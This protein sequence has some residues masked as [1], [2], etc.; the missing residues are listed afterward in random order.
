MLH[1]WSRKVPGLI[2]WKWI[3]QEY[4]VWGI[5]ETADGTPPPALSTFSFLFFVI[6]GFLKKWF[7]WQGC[8]LLLSIQKHECMGAC[9]WLDI[10]SIMRRS[11]VLIGNNFYR[12]SW[13]CKHHVEGEGRIVELKRDNWHTQ[14]W[15][16]INCY[17]LTFYQKYKRL[18]RA[19][20]NAGL[21]AYLPAIQL[22]LCQVAKW[23]NLES[24]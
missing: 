7:F 24:K 11:K 14:M 2:I 13:K 6:L 16:Q 3:L 4:L 20:M 18:M 21:L 22:I 8:F 15:F 10:N 1:L 9:E 23:Q 12:K 5:M 19:N 17:W